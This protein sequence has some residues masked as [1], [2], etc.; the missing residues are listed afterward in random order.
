MAVSFQC[1]TK[2]T[3]TPPPPNKK[4]KEEA[5]GASID[6]Q[7]SSYISV[8]LEPVIYTTIYKINS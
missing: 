3:T 4:K 5:D 7:E 6:I 2:S 1:M 8:V